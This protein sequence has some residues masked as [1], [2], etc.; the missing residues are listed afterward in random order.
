MTIIAQ[1]NCLSDAYAGME[2]LR[3][4]QIPPALSKQGEFLVISVEDDFANH[5]REVLSCDARFTTCV[6][7]GASRRPEQDGFDEWNA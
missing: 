6:W 4:K 5:A 1:L 2:A 3:M 7:T